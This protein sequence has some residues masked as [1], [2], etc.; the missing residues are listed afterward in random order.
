M[1]DSNGQI[2]VTQPSSPAEQEWLAIQRRY[3]AQQMQEGADGT[4]HW[5]C[6]IS[7]SDPDLAQTYRG[8]SELHVSLPNVYPA[9]PPRFAFPA[10][11]SRLDVQQLTRLGDAIAARA[12]E[13]TGTYCLRKLLTWLDNNFYRIAILSNEEQSAT[14]IAAQAID[15]VEQGVREAAIESAVDAMPEDATEVQATPTVDAKKTKK[16][17]CRFFGRGHCK[18]GNQCPFSHEK[19]AA[20]KKPSNSQET[21]EKIE[22]DANGRSEST[23]K[24]APRRNK[25]PTQTAASQGEGA[26]VIVAE[27][28]AKLTKSKNRRQKKPKN[29]EASVVDAGDNVQAAAA[30]DK[31]KKK[32]S[33]KT[34]ANASAEV[35]AS[36]QS[37]P[38]AVEDTRKKQKK[39][40]KFYAKGDCKDGDACKFSHGGKQPAQ[41]PTPVVKKSTDYSSVKGVVAVLPMPVSASVEVIDLQKSNV[42]VTEPASPTKEAPPVEEEVKPPTAPAESPVPSPPRKLSPP[43]EPS[44]P[45]DEWS[46]IQQIAL[47]LALK[48]YPTVSNGTKEDTRTRWR[49]IA[50]AVGSKS[51]NECIDRFK[52]LSK[53]V[54][55]EQLR[56]NTEQQP[57]D[58]A[59]PADTPAHSSAAPATEVDEASADARDPRII[60]EHQRVA[61]VETE[62]ATHG[63]Q[64][65]LEELF[66]YQTGTLIPQRLICQLQCANCPLKFDARLSLSDPRI[67]QWCPRC[68]VLHAV[69][70]RPTF[71]HAHSNV[72]AYVD[73]ENSTVVDVLP[74]DLLATCLECGAEVLLPQVVSGRRAEQ[75]C[76]TCH[77]KLA[78]MTKRYI[79]GQVAT[80]RDGSASTVPVKSSKTKKTV[81]E[82]FVIGQP[83][84]RNGVCEH[85]KHS[86][87]WFRFQ[88]CGKAFACDVCHDASDC[89]EANLGKIASRM[90]CGL[91][92]KEQSA[93]VK[94]CSCGNEVGR[95]TNKTTHWEGGKG[96]RNPHMMSASDKQKFRGMNKTENQ[97]SKRVGAEAKARRLARELLDDVEEK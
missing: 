41:K 75:S 43:S 84:P 80:T 96:C 22:D 53:L 8:D 45:S 31:R 93:S 25:Q 64:I 88:C 47:D 14:N 3:H 54:R 13:L 21:E 48:R 57:S 39:R 91:C 2:Q 97:K 29:E 65:R 27:G 30:A 36:E 85:Y 56:A 38:V 72:V 81:I 11:Q 89:A 17:R 28:D 51:L 44:P 19:K 46:E 20:A 69:L 87:R 63:A 73:T 79:G 37:K 42:I 58:E 66:L 1:S 68:S 77:T 55:A 90:I 23:S 95:K 62:P 7:L 9:E 40:C 71:A 67:Q 82:T 10:W 60:P 74:S 35:R 5:R 92:S 32:S 86:F 33:S 49:N 94:V 34:K 18:S 15:I 76:F 26:V 12:D 52:Y 6:F 50:A 59:G 61:A 78:I 16:V 4:Q 83:L 70:L 24:E